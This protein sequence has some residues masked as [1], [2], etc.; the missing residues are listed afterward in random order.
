MLSGADG[1]GDGAWWQGSGGSQWRV[2]Q[3]WLKEVGREVDLLRT[4]GF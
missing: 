3:H 4:G 2:V 1:G